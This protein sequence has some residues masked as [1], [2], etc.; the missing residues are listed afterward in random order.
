MMAPR[1]QDSF[2]VLGREVR[3]FAHGGAMLDYISSGGD[4]LRPLVLIQ[5]AEYPGWPSGDFCALAEQAGFRTISLR[6]PGFGSLPPA[7]DIGRQV[8][9]ILAFLDGLGGGRSVVVTTGTSNTLGY[10]L[11]GKPGVG[12]TVLANCC[13][14]YDP[15]AEIRPDWFARS[16]E[17]TLTSVTGARMA[18][19]GLKSARGIF[20]KYWVTENFMQ[21]SPGDLEYLERNRELF[22]EAMDCVHDGLDIHTFLMELRST[23]KQDP[24]LADGCFEGLPVVSVSGMETSE[25][26]KAAI[27]AE[28]G[29]VGV[30]LHFFRSGD[31]LVVHAS[32]GELMALL[33]QYP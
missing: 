21:K 1:I 4:T 18:L 11:A 16:I 12:L 10:R 22:A 25:T 31:A 2:D 7:P 28:A 24:V 26:W 6:R 32:A 5:S 23:L 3:S 13:F 9:L 27:R 33:R 20:S 19:M 8:S 29:R 30:P 15:M 14:N 17:H